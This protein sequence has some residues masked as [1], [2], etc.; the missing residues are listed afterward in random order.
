MK[1]IKYVIVSI[2]RIY[3]RDL[4]FMHKIDQSAVQW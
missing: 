4:I 1:I 3:H 2:N